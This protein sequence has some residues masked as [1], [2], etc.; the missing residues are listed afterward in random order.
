VDIRPGGRKYVTM[1]DEKKARRRRRKTV[2]KPRM[3]VKRQ[4]ESMNICLI[5]DVKTTHSVTLQGPGRGCEQ[6]H[7]E[8][9]IEDTP[10]MHFST[11]KRLSTD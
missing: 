10:R 5:I 8:S 2:K 1:K 4:R 7:S 11:V 3:T 6:K 9:R